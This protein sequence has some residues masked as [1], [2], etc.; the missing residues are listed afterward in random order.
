MPSE[1]NDDCCKR[2]FPIRALHFLGQI[3][4]LEQLFGTVIVPPA[5]A[6]ELIAPRRQFSP[7]D[8]SAF[9]NFEVREP[10]DQQ[11]VQKYVETVDVGEAQAIVLAIEL[12][13]TLLSMKWLVASLRK[14]REYPTW[15]CLASYR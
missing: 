15:E 3:A 2:H 10:D 8:V 1:A 7:I 5:V 11:L 9:D 14:L 4:L 12:K 6:Q 13:G